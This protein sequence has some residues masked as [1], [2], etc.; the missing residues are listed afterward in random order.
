MQRK[1]WWFLLFVSSLSTGVA[2]TTTPPLSIGISPAVSFPIAKD[3]EFFSVGGVTDVTIGY[4]FPRLPFLNVGGGIG[5][6][7]VPVELDTSASLLSGRRIMAACRGPARCFG[8]AH[9]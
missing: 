8:G 2:E 9:P 1:L 3:S 4:R 6:S 7:L 5:Y